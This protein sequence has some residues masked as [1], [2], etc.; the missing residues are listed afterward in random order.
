MAHAASAAAQ[1][2]FAEL[3]IDAVVV[4][5]MTETVPATLTATVPETPALT[6]MALTVSLLV[7]TTATPRNPTRSATLVVW[8]VVCSGL[9]AGRVPSGTTLWERPVATAALR[10]MAVPAPASS[11]VAARLIRWAPKAPG[12]R[13]MA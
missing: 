2:I 12:A 1:L 7:A 10:A 6:P 3:P 4:T 8:A 11:R 9:A 13:T 5:L